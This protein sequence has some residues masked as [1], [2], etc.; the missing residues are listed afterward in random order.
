MQNISKY[1]NDWKTGN[2]YHYSF[3]IKASYGAFKNEQ[4]EVEYIDVINSDVD[5]S[6]VDEAISVAKEWESHLL[7][8]IVL[9]SDQK[10]VHKRISTKPF[11]IISDNQ[12]NNIASGTLEFDDESGIS[13][14]LNQ[15]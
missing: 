2:V 4:G 6:T 12:Q 1:L 14:W 10:T 9:Y 13:T 7:E 15:A 11:Y 5:A 3:G 8:R